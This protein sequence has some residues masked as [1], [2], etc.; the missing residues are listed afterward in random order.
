AVRR[1]VAAGRFYPA[2][3]NELAALVDRLLEAA[4]QPV[5]PTGGLRALGVPHAGY[6]YSGAVAAAGFAAVGADAAGLRV[7]LL[8]PSHFV[9]IRRPAISEADA[10]ETPLGTVPVDQELSATALEAGAVTDE[11][12]HGIDHALEVELPFLQR[13]AGPGLRVVPIAVGPTA[14]AAELVA[15]LAP[16]ALIVVSSDLSHYHADAAAR[17]IDSRTAQAVLALDE[18]AVGDLDACGVHALRALLRHAR[19][20]GWT[21]TLLDL[22]TLADV[23]GGLWQVVGY[24]AFAFTAAD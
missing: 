7:V 10:W 4:P 15:A 17:R 14:G 19:T 3:P 12:P 8:G 5:L 24:G 6:L 20:E 21:A 13:R 2:D 1:P 22:R 9:P 11:W 18:A 23:G 16:E